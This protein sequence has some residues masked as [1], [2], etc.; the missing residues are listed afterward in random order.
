MKCIT[1]C[2]RASHA[3][4][5]VLSQLNETGQGR[6]ESNVKANGE[7]RDWIAHR[8]FCFNVSYYLPSAHLSIH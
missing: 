8:S 3:R 4:G 5:C 7:M 6:R 1:G 2:I